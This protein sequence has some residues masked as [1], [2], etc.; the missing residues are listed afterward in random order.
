MLKQKS[1]GL[2][3]ELKFNRTSLTELGVVN[4]VLTT[5]RYDLVGVCDGGEKDMKD[6]DQF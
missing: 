3:K 6:L 5:P 1:G 2:I 4:G